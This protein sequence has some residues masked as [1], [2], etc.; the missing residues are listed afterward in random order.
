MINCLKKSKSNR[1]LS[2]TLHIKLNAR[3]MLTVYVDLKDKLVNRQLSTVKHIVLN[4]QNNV[5]KIYIKFDCKADLK[6]MNT[7][8]FTRQHLWVPIEKTTADIRIKS[9]K[10]HALLLKELNFH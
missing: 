2:G 4:S 6:K 5:S 9:H 1:G 7:D 3:V 10:T 8:N